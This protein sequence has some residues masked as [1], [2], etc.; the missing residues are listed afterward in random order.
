MPSNSPQSHIPVNLH[1]CRPRVEESSNNP[2][3]KAHRYMNKNAPERHKHH[4]GKQVTLRR[5][6][7]GSLQVLNRSLYAKGCLEAADDKEITLRKRHHLYIVLMG[8]LQINPGGLWFAGEQGRGG[9][10]SGWR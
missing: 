1:V 10:G 8:T 9:G 4:R 6:K 3:S 2:P 5:K 7:K